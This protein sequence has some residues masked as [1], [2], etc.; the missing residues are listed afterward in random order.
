MSS[1]RK[2]NCKMSHSVAAVLVRIAS[3]CGEDR[4]AASTNSQ[5][6]GEKG[7]HGLVVCPSNMV[8]VAHDVVLLALINL[9]VCQSR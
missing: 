2:F 9:Q 6:V 5:K 7:L 3:R 4:N 1:E 8:V